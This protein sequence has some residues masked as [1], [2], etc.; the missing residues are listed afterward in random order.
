MALLVKNLCLLGV[1]VHLLS[2]QPGRY[3]LDRYLARARAARAGG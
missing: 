3:S 1:C 2:H